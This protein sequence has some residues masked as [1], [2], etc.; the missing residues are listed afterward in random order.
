MSDPVS[1]IRAAIEGGRG[2][3]LALMPLPRVMRAA[4][5]LRSDAREIVAR[6]AKGA[7]EPDPLQTLKLTEVP[8]P[9][10][11]FGEAVVA[12]MASS[13]NYNTVWA[14][15]FEPVPTF[16]MLDFYAERYPSLK[17]HADAFHVHGSDA[18]GVVMRVGPGVTHVKV[19]D[20]VVVDPIWMASEE[21]FDT[22]D[23]MASGQALAWGYETNFGGM[24]DFALVQA[25]QLLPKAPHL[26]WEE[27]ASMPVGSRTA[28]RMLVSPAGA[29]ME[30]GD[31]VL[32]WGAASGIGLFATQYV[33]NGGGIP[34]AVVSSPRKAEL[35]KS[36]GVEHVIDRSVA[37]FNLNTPGGP[38]HHGIQVL[39]KLVRATAG[40]DPDIVF[41]HPGR[42][43]F[44]ASVALARRGGTV[45]TCGSTT[46]YQHTYDNRALWLGVKRIVGSHGATFREGRRANDLARRGV[47]HP[48]LAESVPLADAASATAKV[49]RNEHVGKVGILCLASREGLGVK[50]AALRRKVKDRLDLCR[51]SPAAS[52]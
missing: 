36:Y 23:V 1:D 40:G 41:E 38:D 15:T 2:D 27:A 45:V 48:T 29:R 35:L 46:G 31:R 49:M 37:S 4:V 10:P 24:A 7:V 3:A 6:R 8:V 22:E 32:I 25:R 17:R 39:R 34:I 30:Q 11:G 28:Y 18:A 26:T 47:I 9:Q 20:E 12:V 5:T 42:D 50:D 16:E 13:I 44:A 33:L 43:T 19:G 51:T 21:F 14:S 52:R